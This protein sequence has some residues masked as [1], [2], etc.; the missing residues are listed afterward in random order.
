MLKSAS[1]PFFRNYYGGGGTFKIS[2]LKFSL[3]GQNC[4][5]K[6]F[7]YFQNIMSMFISVGLRPKIYDILNFNFFSKRRNFYG[8]GARQILTF[9]APLQYI[10]EISFHQ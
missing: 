2:N 1:L 5:I 7:A 6:T 9:Q 8:G 4:C 3:F 10:N